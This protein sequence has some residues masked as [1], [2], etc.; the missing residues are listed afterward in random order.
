MKNLDQFRATFPSPQQRMDKLVPRIEEARSRLG[1]LTPEEIVARS[2][3]TFE[4]DGRYRLEFAGRMYAI[5]Q[6]FTVRRADTGDEAA[7]FTQSIILM[8]LATADGT[9]SFAHW[10]SFHELPDGQFYEQAF[11]GYSGE[12]LIRGLQS[13]L[14]AFQRAA[15]KLNGESI[16]LG[17]AA[18]VFRILPRLRLAV[19]MYAGDEDFPAQARVLFEATA[20][21]YL[22]TDGLAILGGQLVGQIVKAAKT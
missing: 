14:E 17:D 11:R 13:N 10:I 9:P 2:G 19:V 15:L 7:S 12:E 16:G 5:D 6:S 18:F 8:Y 20:P 21:R 3:C 1:A 4:G 22:S